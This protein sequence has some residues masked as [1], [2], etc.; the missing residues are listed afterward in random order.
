MRSSPAH[1]RWPRR[2]EATNGMN[3]ERVTRFADLASAADALLSGEVR[4]PKGPR[5]LQ[6]APEAPKESK[7]LTKAQKSKAGPRKG[8][9]KRRWVELTCPCGFK[10]KGPSIHIHARRCERAKAVKWVPVV[11]T[12][13]T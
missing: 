4:A 13:K 12:K 10:C 3:R 7:A 8:P 1:A 9:G 5:K 11:K 2:Y 6:E